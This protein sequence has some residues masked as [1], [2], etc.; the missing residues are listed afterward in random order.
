MNTPSIFQ[1]LTLSDFFSVRKFQ[2]G[3]FSIKYHIPTHIVE[4]L[5]RNHVFYTMCESHKKR[6]YYCVVDGEEKMILDEHDSN[7]VL[8]LVFSIWNFPKDEWDNLHEELSAHDFIDAYKF[9]KRVPCGSLLKYCQ[10]RDPS[11]AFRWKLLWKFD[12]EG[13]KEKLHALLRELLVENGFKILDHKRYK[14][15]KDNDVI[16]KKLYDDLYAVFY[17]FSK[18]IPSGCY[19]LKI[20]RFSNLESVAANVHDESIPKVETDLSASCFLLSFELWR[21][22]PLLRGLIRDLHKLEFLDTIS[23]YNECLSL[24]RENRNHL[25]ES[26]CQEYRITEDEFYSSQF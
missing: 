11:E 10:E 8:S 20:S 3:G 2:K 22:Y 23:E 16:Y 6:I 12:N 17:W 5:Y 9:R 15:S 14:I 13:C 18:S 21:H 7:E 26:I 4:Y 19:D 1:D 25:V 24:C